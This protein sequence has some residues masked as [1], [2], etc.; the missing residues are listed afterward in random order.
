VL[1][2]CQAEVQVRRRTNHRS[3]INDDAGTDLAKA[4]I[5]VELSYPVIEE[6]IIPPA[7]STLYPRNR[8]IYVRLNMRVSKED[9][10]EIA[11]ELKSQETEQFEQTRIT[12][13][14][15]GKGPDM[16]PGNS[17]ARFRGRHGATANLILYDVCG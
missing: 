12:F 14:L 10:R 16:G 1:R 2:V 11:L 6:F 15:P 7:K 9:L 5:Q 13:F 17:D 3:Q 4:A 8:N